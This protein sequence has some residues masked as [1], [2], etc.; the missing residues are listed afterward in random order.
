MQPAPA[1]GT[2]L[3]TANYKTLTGEQR[4]HR[5]WKGTMLAPGLYIGSVVG[6]SLG[7]I[8][9]APPEWG[10]GVEGYAKRSAN[11]VGSFAI[12]ET[13]LQGG[14]AL[15]GY[16]P[17]YIHCDCRGFAR[18]TGHAILW[19]FVTKNREGKTR[20]DLPTLA[21]AYGSGM[22]SVY[23]YPARFNPLTDGVRF[24]TQQVGY[25]VGVDVLREFSPEILRLLHLQN[26][27]RWYRTD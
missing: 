7:Q 12:Q 6:A 15:L 16:D 18:R 9:N 25:D 19:S 3:T 2:I 21:G 22:L 10:Q 13:I 14:S 23:W 20:V 1:A 24:G 4:W 26:R 27:A 11:D 5:Y 17:R 8:G